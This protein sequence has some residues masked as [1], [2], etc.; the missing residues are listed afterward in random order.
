[1]NFSNYQNLRD[2][3]TVIEAYYYNTANDTWKPMGG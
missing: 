1:M 3:F 2:L